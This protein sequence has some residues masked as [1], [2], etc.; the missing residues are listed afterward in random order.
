M[1]KRKKSRIL[2]LLSLFL[3]KK[4]PQH[5]GYGFAICTALFI[6]SASLSTAFSSANPTVFASILCSILPLVFVIA[7]PCLGP[8]QSDMGVEK[9]AHMDIVISVPARNRIESDASALSSVNSLLLPLDEHTSVSG[10]SDYT[11]L[12]SFRSLDFWL[13]FIV[14]FS[15]IG[16][17]ITVV[18]NMFEIVISRIPSKYTGQTLPQSSV[19]HANDAATLLVMVSTQIRKYLFFSRWIKKKK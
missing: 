5:T 13:T 3:V 16:S 14:F 9:I 10:K 2:T 6:A 11:L 15:G 1:K 12:R 19:P 18:N 8:Q 17:G 7:L 4:F